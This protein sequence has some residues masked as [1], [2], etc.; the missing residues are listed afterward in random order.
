M[1]AASREQAPVAVRPVRNGCGFG[2]PGIR[3]IAEKGGLYFLSTFIGS[4]NS[5]SYQVSL[6]DFQPK[7]DAPD[8]LTIESGNR[9]PNVAGR[10]DFDRPRGSFRIAG[11]ATFNKIDGTERHQNEP[12]LGLLL[13]GL[14]NLNEN[15]LIKTHLVRTDGNNSALADF[16]FSDLDMA[17]DAA[18]GNV[19]NLSTIGGQIALEHKWD[20][21]FTSAFG[22][23]FLDMDNEDYQAG[24]A[25]AHGYQVLG[26]IFVRPGDWLQ[27]LVLAAEVEYATQTTKDGSD[28]ETTRI[29]ILAYYDW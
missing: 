21:N 18:T 11:L 15:N 3:Q 25:F 5:W 22:V 27:G 6:E 8:G 28:G 13:G 20:E 4:T 12:G 29:S 26:T 10:I 24:D 23:G 1:Y 9:I 14:V 2:L 7:I 19:S 16:G 17:Y